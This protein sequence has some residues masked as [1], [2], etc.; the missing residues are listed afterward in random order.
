MQKRPIDMKNLNL[1]QELLVTV[2][3]SRMT[4]D[5]ASARADI[6]LSIFLIDVEQVGTQESFVARAINHL[7]L[8][9]LDTR[10]AS[11]LLRDATANTARAIWAYQMKPTVASD[12][13]VRDAFQRWE[14]VYGQVI[15]EAPTETYMD[16]ENARCVGDADYYSKPPLPFFSRVQ[17][18]IG[19]QN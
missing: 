11:E 2:I 17:S 8:D 15:G 4:M 16:I 18:R 14:T 9:M 12:Q 1:Y 7:E 3:E 19:A 5:R 6:L 10:D 13:D